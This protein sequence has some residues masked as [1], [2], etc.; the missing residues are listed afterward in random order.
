MA[1]TMN[2]ITRNGSALLLALS[3]AGLAIAQSSIPDIPPTPA[4]VIDV[5]SIQPFSL[6]TPTK[7]LWRAE[8]PSVRTGYLVVLKVDPGLV[9]PRQIAEPVL[10]VGHQT[11]E[12]VN[13]G[14][15]SG[16]VVAIV[17]GETDP[18]HPNYLDLERELFWFGTPELPERVNARRILAERKAALE[19]GLKPFDKKVIAAARKRGGALNRQETKTSLTHDALR[20]L[21]LTYSPQER[22]LVEG[23]LEPSGR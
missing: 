10:Y 4:P 23:A 18:K 21:V 2:R 20:R 13:V 17:P 16:H 11:A 1:S 3:F 22:P 7:H 5:V 12:R 8:K 9:F 15:R 19:A 14:Y 6:E